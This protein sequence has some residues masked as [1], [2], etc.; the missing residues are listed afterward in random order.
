MYL[1]L[2]LLLTGSLACDRGDRATGDAATGTS[3]TEAA[4]I[5]RDFVEDQLADGNA[6]VELGRLAEQKASSADVREFGAMM[7]RDHQKAGTELKQIASRHDI[8]PEASGAARETAGTSGPMMH[9]EHRDLHERLSKLSGAEF[10]R[11]Y[12]DAMVNAH[13]KAVDAVEEKATDG[14]NAEVK[15]WAAS[16]LPTLKQHLERAK[17]IQANLR[18]TRSDR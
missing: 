5:D 15:Q 2:A 9:E 3:G 18:N 11:E 1:P 4:N 8:Q 17:Q 13:Q 16:T 14:D 6:E 10:D 7:V 12:I